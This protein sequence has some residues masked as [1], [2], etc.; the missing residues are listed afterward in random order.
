[1]GEREK[2]STYGHLE[3]L[4]VRLEILREQIFVLSISARYMVKKRDSSI[5]PGL[6]F[7][8]IGI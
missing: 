1:M 5:D 7:F 3:G 4:E 8:Q 6:G 2:M